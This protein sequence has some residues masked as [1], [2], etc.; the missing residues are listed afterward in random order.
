MLRATH[1]ED[2]RRIRGYDTAAIA[3]RV[4]HKDISTT[5]RYMPDRERIQK[6]YPSLHVYWKDFIHVMSKGGNKN[7]DEVTTMPRNDM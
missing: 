6:I 5:G 4:G 7:D 2:L 1:I 3:M